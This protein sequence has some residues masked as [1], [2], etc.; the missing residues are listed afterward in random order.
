MLNI[1]RE[2]AMKSKTFEDILE[3]EN[4]EYYFASKNPINELAYMDVYHQI[5]H[6]KINLEKD[7]LRIP[8]VSLNTGEVSIKYKDYKKKLI[9]NIEDKEKKYIKMLE[10]KIKK[11]SAL[12]IIRRKLDYDSILDKNK[13]RKRII[14]KERVIFFH[15]IKTSVI[16][17]EKIGLCVVKYQ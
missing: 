9:K 13:D 15:P 10:S 2:N 7:L 8:I 3:I 6:R 1:N 5:V 14:N 4:D 12:F 11:Y 17:Y 16:L